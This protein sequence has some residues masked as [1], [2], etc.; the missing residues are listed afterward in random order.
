[1][2]TRTRFI[3]RLAASLAIVSVVGI[4][5]AGCLPAALRATG[6]PSP[7]SPT[8][9]PTPAAPT[10]TPE[11]TPRPSPTF[12]L[13]T[14]VGGDS[15][16]AIA[17]RFHTTGRSIAFWSRDLHPSLDPTSPDYDPN[18]LEAGWVVRIIPGAEYTVP[19]GPGDSPEPTPTP[20]AEPAAPGPSGSGD[21]P[22]SPGG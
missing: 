5:A 21:A 6:T 7:P 12:M 13:Y 14:V 1:M 4:A 22:A 10:P 16:L 11:P 20:T 15:L 2:S 19:M 18:R 3:R 8:V 17:A 9:G